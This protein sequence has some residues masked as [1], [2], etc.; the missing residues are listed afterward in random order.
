MKQKK[1]FYIFIPIALLLIIV[2]AI[3]FANAYAKDN[4][5]TD[6]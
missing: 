5:K 6:D 2:V 3:N 1:W 4:T